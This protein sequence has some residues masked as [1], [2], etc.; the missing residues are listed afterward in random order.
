M[1]TEPRPIRRLKVNGSPLLYPLWDIEPT[2]FGDASEEEL[3][4]TASLV[5]AD[6]K[7]M[8]TLTRV[9]AALERVYRPSEHVELQIYGGGFFSDDDRELCRQFHLLPWEERLRIVDRFDDQ[10]LRRLGR[11]LIY[12]Q[13]PHLIKDTERRAMDEDISSRRRG[14][15][16]HSSPVWTT[17]ASALSKLDSI[18]SEIS[19]EFRRSF[20]AI[21]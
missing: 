9:A 15:G 1:K 4:R 7:F 17:V 5:R 14:D 12:F 10:R 11:R 13:A 6:G 19:H 16:R 8:S 2:R 3:L 20:T 18:G 21:A